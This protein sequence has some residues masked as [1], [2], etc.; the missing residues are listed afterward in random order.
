MVVQYSDSRERF[1]A[2]L[3]SSQDALYTY[4]FSLLPGEDLGPHLVGDAYYS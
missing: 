3:T 1:V 2:N 4:I